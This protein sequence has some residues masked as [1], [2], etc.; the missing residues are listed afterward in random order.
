[1][2]PFGA[3]EK[4]SIL[5]DDLKRL[6]LFVLEHEPGLSIVITGSGDDRKKIGE[7]VGSI[8]SDRVCNVSGAAT[9]EEITSLIFYSKLYVGVDT[10][11]THLASFLGKKSLV[12]AHNGTPNWLPY[13][14]P[15][16]RILYKI[17][18]CTHSGTEGRD[19]L[20]K[21]RDKKVFP[22]T[23][24]RESVIKDA[25]IEELRNG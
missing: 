3:V 9:M 10:G 16:S 25:I 6:L 4:R 7:L 12:I 2:H 21:C 14:N 18:G 24:V 15:L 8:S 19:H 20:E 23:R 22:L 13:Y 17:E 11:I 1:L 5:G